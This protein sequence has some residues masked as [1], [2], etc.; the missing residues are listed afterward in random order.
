MMT[1][2]ESLG[3]PTTLVEEAEPVGY[4]PHLSAALAGLH[5]HLTS[6]VREVGGAENPY[7]HRAV[8]GSEDKFIGIVLPYSVGNTRLSASMF[9]TE[10][11]Y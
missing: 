8:A 2:G 6:G 9:L 4:T 3:V 10:T 1:R 7:R 11:I 5:E